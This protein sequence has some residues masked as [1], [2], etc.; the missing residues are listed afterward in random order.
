M[1]V[2][3]RECNIGP[4]VQG[5]SFVRRPGDDPEEASGVFQRYEC[6]V[7]CACAFG[8]VH[9]VDEVG[10]SVSRAGLCPDQR[11]VQIIDATASPCWADPVDR[12]GCLRGIPALTELALT[13]RDR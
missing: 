12:P 5:D 6:P 3:R 1:P 2:V 4:R 10:G 11:D 13:R 7:G 8:V 9:A